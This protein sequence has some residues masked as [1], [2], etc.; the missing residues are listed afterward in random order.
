MKLE[1][2]LVK[3]DRSL[4]DPRQTRCPS[5]TSASS[6]R[7]RTSPAVRAPIGWPRRAQLRP[8]SSRPSRCVEYETTVCAVRAWHGHR[9][10]PIPRAGHEGGERSTA[11]GRGRLRTRVRF[12]ASSGPGTKRVRQL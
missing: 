3:R 7:A 5:S 6:S 11:T 8:N 4:I 10:S 1:E 12:P 9:R 2:L